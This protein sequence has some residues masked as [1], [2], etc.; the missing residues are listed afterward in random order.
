VLFKTCD[1]GSVKSRS[2]STSKVEPTT[3]SYAA[4][5]LPTCL[6][7][8][9]LFTFLPDQWS[10]RMWE[11]TNVHWKG[12]E[13]ARRDRRPAGPS[14]GCSFCASTVLASQSNSDPEPADATAASR[15]RSITDGWRHCRRAAAFYLQRLLPRN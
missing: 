5:Y 1:A 6:L 7:T 2:Y 13:S 10:N 4:H 11:R 3:F 8:S 14:S 15:R 12:L 9:Y